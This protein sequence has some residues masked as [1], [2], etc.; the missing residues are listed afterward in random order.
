MALIAKEGE[1]TF[2]PVPPGM[3][4]ARCYRVV[5]L[6]T[7]K[8]EY[9]GTIKHLPKVMLQFEVHG[10]DDNGKAEPRF[11]KG[12]QCQRQ[13]DIAGIA[14]NQRAEIGAPVKAQDRGHAPEQHGQHPVGQG[15]GQGE[16]QADLRLLHALLLALTPVQSTGEWCTLRQGVR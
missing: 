14:E 4:L 12:E 3:H 8:S 13:A 6:G 16:R 2:T 11:A 5:D 15:R 7:Q 1:G 10:E 9:L